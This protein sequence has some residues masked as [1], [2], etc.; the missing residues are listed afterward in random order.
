VRPLVLL[1]LSPALAGVLQA[2]ASIAS[3]LWR[4]AA[5][6]LVT[7]PAL[8][9]DGTAPMW[10]AAVVLPPGGPGLMLGA[11]AVHA[12][13]EV[14]LNAG[15]VAFAWRLGGVGT[16][17]ATYA[18][19]GLS[20]I[21]YTESS[22][23]V[24]GS[25]AVDAQTASIGFARR[26]GPHLVGGAALR[27]LEGRQSGQVAAQPA[28]DVGARYAPSAHLELGAATQFFDPFFHD[29]QQAASLSLGARYQSSP[30]GAWGTPARA[31][32]RYGVTVLRGEDPQQLLTLGLVLA[33]LAVD[34]GI[35]REGVGT[36]AIWR[37]RMGL[38]LGVGRYQVTISRDGG[39]NGFGPTWA[40]ALTA[41]F[42]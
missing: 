39:V 22:P 20:D 34:G 37:S 6:T 17:S 28:L 19:A 41:L 29:A 24:I 13:A 31:V 15:L 2:Q 4:L 30:F 1:A 10:T 7:P 8:A 5:G 11:E 36:D 25:I 35:V 32:V 16:L 40:F 23:E 42:P 21:G 38:G 9:A 14:G 26:F 33:N 3:D 12:P 18:K 27:W